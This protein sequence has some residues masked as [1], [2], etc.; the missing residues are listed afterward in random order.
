M[1]SNHSVLKHQFYGP[2]NNHS[3]VKTYNSKAYVAFVFKHHTIKAY[4]GRRIL[5]LLERI[6]W[7]ELLMDNKSLIFETRLNRSQSR[8]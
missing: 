6:G 2:S 5:S 8:S 3:Q 1:H 7:S 4:K